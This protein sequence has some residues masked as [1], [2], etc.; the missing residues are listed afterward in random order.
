MYRGHAATIHLMLPFGPHLL[1]ID[2]EGV[3]KVRDI[4]TGAEYLEMTFNNEKTEVSDEYS[5]RRMFSELENLCEDNVEVK[6]EYADF[7]ARAGKFE[8]AYN[9]LKKVLDVKS[10]IHN[11]DQCDVKIKGRIRNLERH[12]ATFH[13]NS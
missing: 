13:P 6:K 4:K 12:K 8:E 11:C 7:E 10:K 5:A 1:T 2:T 9:L 3:L